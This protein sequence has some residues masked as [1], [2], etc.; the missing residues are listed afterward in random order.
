MPYHQHNLKEQQM[1]AKK[2]DALDE[3]P[4]AKMPYTTESTS[5]GKIKEPD[6]NFPMNKKVQTPYKEE[7]L[8][9]GKYK[10]YKQL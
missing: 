2:D 7:P 9:Y 8:P 6:Y 4:P 5:Y 10:E 1:A 3:S